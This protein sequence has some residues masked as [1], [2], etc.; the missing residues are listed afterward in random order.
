MSFKKKIDM[1][2][3]AKK[4]EKL[5]INKMERD[6]HLDGTLYKGL[7]KD[8]WV[9]DPGLSKDIVRKYRIRQSWWD[10]DWETG[11]LDMFE[12][13]TEPGNISSDN[14]GKPLSENPTELFQ[15]IVFGGTEYVIMPK[16]AFEGNY[17]LMPLEEI[18]MHE[19]ELERKNDE[20]IRKDTQIMGL[21]ELF[22]LM[23]SGG[24]SAHL[25][26]VKETK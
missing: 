6:L 24:A 26:E 19:K 23:A 22:K 17:R 8:D 12:P 25:P 2:L 14:T 11:S 1:L 9:P 7:K 20:L 5:S 16:S 10:K 13:E 18:T 3:E 21:Y 15:K 4:L